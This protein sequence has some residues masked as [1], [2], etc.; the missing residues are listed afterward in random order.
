MSVSVTNSPTYNLSV[1]FSGAPEPQKKQVDV[2]PL[3]QEVVCY[4]QAEHIQYA[5]VA[6]SLH[7]A[8]KFAL[9]P[10]PNPMQI[11]TAQQQLDEHLFL[12]LNRI[13]EKNGEYIEQYFSGRKKPRICIKSSLGL[14]DNDFVTD[15]YRN[16]NGKISDK[17]SLDSNAGFKHILDTGKYYLCN[18]IP[19][20]AKR[21]EYF[22]PRLNAK[23]AKIY[24]PPRFMAAR[25]ALRLSVN[26]NWCDCWSGYGATPPTVEAC[27]K[28]TMI[29]PISLSDR[30]T[31]DRL[32]HSL[33]P[34]EARTANRILFGY[35]CLDSTEVDF[36]TNEDI[37]IGYIFADLISFYFFTLV[38][39]T[40]LSE[41]HKFAR[42]RTKA[43]R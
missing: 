24:S 25:K 43:A 21:E 38:S 20:S 13:C 1:S 8:L 7:K 5:A 19:E 11:G 22:N 42:S 10:K 31:S 35:L 12:G 34:Q 14:D 18:N 15:I 36:F 6:H 16:K 27:Y 41:T 29:V 9:H 28:S 33:F 37:A 3:L 2:V 39:L 32:F 23:A 17:I 26:D 30:Q 40:L 4:N